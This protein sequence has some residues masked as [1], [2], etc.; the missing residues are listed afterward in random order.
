MNIPKTIH[1]TCNLTLD[2]KEIYND[3]EYEELKKLDYKEATEE[4]KIRM[5][6][7]MKHYFDIMDLNIT[8][9]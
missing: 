8:V 3:D 6:E 9:E 5:I 1:I 4:I 7:E 2:V